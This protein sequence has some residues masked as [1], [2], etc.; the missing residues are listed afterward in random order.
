MWMMLNIFAWSDG[1]NKE[2]ALEMF[3]MASSD[4]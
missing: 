3:E 2:H 1:I 4:Y